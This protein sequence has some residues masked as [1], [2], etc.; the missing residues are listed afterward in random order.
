MAR[1]GFEAFI[2]GLCALRFFGG[3]VAPAGA[4]AFADPCGVGVL[5]G[6]PQR[7]PED[8]LFAPP[9]RSCDGEYP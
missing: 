4:D 6:S 5:H 7:H 1:Q 2:E 8:A 9:R 3:G